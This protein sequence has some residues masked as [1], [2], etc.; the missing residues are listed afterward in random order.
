MLNREELQ[1]IEDQNIAKIEKTNPESLETEPYIENSDYLEKIGIFIDKEDRETADGFI[2]LWPEDFVVE[3][4]NKSGKI[5]S[6]LSDGGKNKKF[7]PKSKYSKINLVKCNIGTLEAISD[8][9]SRLNIDKKTIRHSGLKDFDAIT[10]QNLSIK[11]NSLIDGLE[12]IKS[13]YFF[14]K[15][16]EATNRPLSPG[17]LK[18]NQFTILIRTNLNEKSINGIKKSISDIQKNGFWN[19]YYTQRFGNNGRINGHLLGKLFI[20]E[21]YE[22]AFKK[23]ITEAPDAS[24]KLIKGI[25]KQVSEEY[26]NWKNI[27]N[28]MSPYPITFERE[29]NMVRF[30][31]NNPDDFLGAVNAQENE[32]KLWVLGF[33]S[34]LFNL[35]LSEFE[36]N[37]EIPPKEIP[38]IT[39]NETSDQEI[40]FDTLEIIG[41]KKEKIDFNK[42]NDFNVQRAKY[43]VETKKSVEIKNVLL[44]PQGLIFQFSLD[45]GSYATTFLSHVINLVSGK[46][47]ENFSRERVDITKA[48]GRESIVPL[49]E[50]F[51]RVIK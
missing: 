44:A 39:S 50:Q 36:K 31:I 15:D 33:A 23:F 28:L 5:V 21:K 34:W 17:E 41:M 37:K 11:T 2:K 32:I 27:E 29:L 46:I 4:I 42:L 35:K 22:E 45:K 13:D 3:E 16:L 12:K 8:I 25:Y 38:L 18:G 10:S 14:I 49:T 51:R 40:Y 26:G 7:D 20:E 6:I 43:P 30:L 9:A 48:V 47:P 19:Y 1:K 24:N